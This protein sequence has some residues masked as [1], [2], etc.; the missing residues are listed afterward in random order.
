MVVLL[1]SIRRF[2]AGRWGWVVELPPAVIA[3][4]DG[5]RRGSAWCFFFYVQCVVLVGGKL[6]SFFS[7]FSHFFFLPTGNWQQLRAD[8]VTRLEM[9]SVQSHTEIET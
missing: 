1:G 7:L 9:G 6:A 5:W 8:E 4:E 3:A 2:A